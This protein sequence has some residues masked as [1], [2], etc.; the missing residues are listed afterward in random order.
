MYGFVVNQLGGDGAGENRLAFKTLC[1]L[2]AKDVLLGH[3]LEEDLVGLPLDFKIAFPHPVP[4]LAKRGIIITVGGD[5][6]HWGKKFRNALDN[7]SRFL[8]F[9]GKFKDLNILFDVWTASGDRAVTH[10]ASL[11]KY[12][13]TLD[14]FNLNSY[15]KMRVF[16]ALQIMSQTCIRMIREVCEEEEDYDI[17]DFGPMIAL[18]DK[19]DRLVDIMNARTN[20]STGKTVEY[21]NRPR[22]RHVM[23]MFDVLRLF[24]EWRSEVGGFNEKFITKQTWEDLVWMVFGLAGVACFLKE[25]G[26]K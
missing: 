1:T 6:P 16:L 12:R 11:R 7:S 24:E 3:F 2:S 20:D 18:F 17:D 15:L 9:R 14:H 10:R 5:M 4:W 21:I 25:D 13:F 22:H 19:V 26:S 23:E 8:K